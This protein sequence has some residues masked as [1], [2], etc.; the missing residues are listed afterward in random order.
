MGLGS[1]GHTAHAGEWVLNP[2][3]QNKLA[4]WLGTSIGKLHDRLGFTGGPRSY[5]GGG[6]VTPE[7]KRIKAITKGNYELPTIMPE[8][9]SGIFKE[10]RRVYEAINNISS[11]GK[12]GKQLSKF[13]DNIRSLTDQD[14]LLDTMGA[15][16]EAMG[17]RLQRDIDLAKVGFKRVGSKLLRMKH[18]LAN[19][20]KLAEEAIEMYEKIGEKLMQ[21]R[22]LARQGLERTR[23]KIAEIRI[24]GVSAKEEDQY[25]ELMAARKKFTDT[26]DDIDSK[27]A[28]NRASLYESRA[29]KFEART[30][31]QMRPSN[32]KLAVAGALESVGST[33]GRTDLQAAAGNMQLGALQSQQ[34][35][36]GDR[37]K[38]AQALAKKDPRWQ[39]AADDLYKQWLDTN[40][41]VIQQVHDNIQGGLD[42]VNKSFERQ[43]ASLDLWRRLATATGNTDAIKNLNQQ[44]IDIQKN[45]VGELEKVMAQAQAA[46]DVG[47]VEQIGD[48]I[49]DLRVKI[50]E[51]TA[52]MFD[53]ALAA[54]DAAYS[55]RGA[56]LDLKQRAVDLTG[57]MGDRLGGLKGS[58]G[59]QGERLGMMND[60]MN[61][62]SRLLAEMTA[63]G[64]IANAETIADL[65]DKMANLGMEIAEEN[66]TRKELVFQYRQAATDIITGRASRSTGLIGSAAG[67]I[68]K[69]NQI[70][71][72]STTA[73]ALRFAEQIRKVLVETGQQ[74]AADV[75][76]ALTSGE[77]G[78]Q[79][80]GI[81]ARARGSLPGRPRHLRREAGRAGSGHRGARSDHGRP[82]E[83]SLRRP[84]RGDAGEHHRHHRQHRPAPAAQ[85][86]DSQPPAV[87]FLLVAVVPRGDLHRH[88]R[89]SAPIHG[90]DD[91]EQRSL[92]Q[93]RLL[94]PQAER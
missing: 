87:V 54:T 23:Q 93:E 14:G 62:Y 5:E 25:R 65:R 13:F 91:A 81:L 59:V 76:E 58:M 24:Q 15:A 39:A 6:N 53:E 2:G 82:R 30:E 89:S 55:R 57:R 85:R 56:G 32:I 94:D 74:I 26:L 40:A 69:L 64:A 61:D 88:G 29:S 47:L 17:T 11:K 83:G 12:V 73:D 52:A 60:Q 36:I 3:Q 77:F 4:N 35:I 10:V 80:A 63:P 20:A 1:R 48:Q 50:V 46:G 92:L 28:E 43:N 75:R 49:A 19:E 34:K 68:E 84:D 33:L 31:R 71:G 41:S 86:A 70:A 7:E 38:A 79:A 90:P 8:A 27:W 78:A 37:L 21:E 44:A 16:I 22:R 66:Q 67:I 9:L 42:G 18:P 51:G 72:S 45:Q